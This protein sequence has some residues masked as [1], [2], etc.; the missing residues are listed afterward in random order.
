[1]Q[2]VLQSYSSVFGALLDLRMMAWQLQQCWQ[3]IVQ[4]QGNARLPVIC[5]FLFF[6][7]RT[8]TDSQ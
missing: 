1:M 6:T 3:D 8:S 2:D 5:S 4:Q 7:T